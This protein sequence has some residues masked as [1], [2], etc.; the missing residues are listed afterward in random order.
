MDL[1]P[2]QVKQVKLDDVIEGISEIRTSMVI[3]LI[4]VALSTVILLPL[5]VYYGSS[6]N[7]SVTGTP[8]QP[9]PNVFY[10]FMPLFFVIAVIF[11]AALVP[12]WFLYQ[13]FK[14]LRKVGDRFSLG[15]FGT[16]ITFI[17]LPILALAFALIFAWFPSLLSTNNSS[18]L[19][20]VWLFLLIMAGSLMV[21]AGS[22]MVAVAIHRIGVSYNSELVRWGSILLIVFLLLGTIFLII[23][24]KEVITDIERIKKT[25][26]SSP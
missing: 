12:L 3:Q 19:P 15:F 6:A 5:Y 13:G 23:G 16:L 21:F 26:A 14:K 18:F 7:F 24:L 1:R 2:V 20:F 22:I 17:A 25:Q 10:V 8:S 11:A 9:Y 4:I